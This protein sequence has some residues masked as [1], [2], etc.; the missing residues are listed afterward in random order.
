M[1]WDRFDRFDRL[2]NDPRFDRRLGTLARELDVELESFQSNSEGAL[3]DF[4][5]EAGARVDGFIVN[6]AG[7]THTSVALLDALLAVGRPYVEVHL[8]NPAAR[9]PFRRRS[10][11]A[12][13]A[14]GVV[15]GFGAASYELG[16]RGL[17]AALHA[18]PNEQGVA[19]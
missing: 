2:P 16:L 10:L 15:Q 17:V 7:F 13:K 11:L 14:R 18:E 12:P 9:E 4:L 6:A 8:S 5:Q 1:G 19:R 3:I